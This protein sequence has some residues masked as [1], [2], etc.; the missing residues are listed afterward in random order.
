MEQICEC[1]ICGRRRHVLR[2]ENTV[3][4][5]RCLAAL[6]EALGE[7]L[8]HSAPQRETD[9]QRQPLVP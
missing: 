9:A 7:K 2:E 4:C 6:A 1:M 5:A 3:L 8:S